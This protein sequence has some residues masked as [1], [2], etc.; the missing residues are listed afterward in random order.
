MNDGPLF[1]EN[2]IRLMDACIV[3][4]VLV[5]KE[6]K[7]PI[8]QPDPF[9]DPTVKL[10]MDV[11]PFVEELQNEDLGIAYGE[12]L[13][14]KPGNWLPEGQ[15]KLYVEIGCYKGK[16]LIEMASHHPEDHFVGFDITFKRVVTTA[17]RARKYGLENITTSLA[18][19]NPSS[20]AQLFKPGEIDVLMIFFPDPWSK[21]KK[22]T[23]RLVQKEFCEVAKKFLNPE[24]YLWFKTDQQPYFENASEALAQTGWHSCEK[25]IFPD[26][27]YTT[28][29]ENTF[30]TQG[31]PTFEG[32]WSPQLAKFTSK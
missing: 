1:E 24:G 13:K 29:F 5:S 18:N 15:S 8:R 32:V 7:M 26:E 22:T 12:G 31:L 19:I 28:P 21:K 10:R 6:N 20:F 25:V 27:S 17:K 14:K 9:K 23:H 3:L 11:N 2:R 16:T 4:T 30:Q